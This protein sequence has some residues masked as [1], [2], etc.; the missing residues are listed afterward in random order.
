ME[1]LNVCSYNCQNV[2]TSCNTTRELCKK[3]ELILLQEHWLSSD[4][5]NY[6]SNIDVNFGAFGMSAMDNESNILK[7]RPYGGTAIMWSK[8]IAPLCNIKNYDDERIL[9]LT[10]KIDNI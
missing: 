9:G 3:N 1:Y 6:L 8:A 10:V 7:G 2:K 5:L 4:D